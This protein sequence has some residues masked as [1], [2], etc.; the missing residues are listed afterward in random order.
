[1]HRLNL[2]IIKLVDLNTWIGEVYLNRNY[3]ATII[4]LDSPTVSPRGFLHRYYSSDGGNF[5]NFNNADYDRVYDAVLTEADTARRVGL[6]REAQ[7]IITED[8][9]SV[10]IQ[11][12]FY[13]IVLRSG[14]F[15]GALDY[16]LYVIDFSSLYKVSKH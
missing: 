15:S 16:P 11:D 13:F 9:A 3:Q 5:I 10:F 8:A 2:S 7:R 6:Y 12:I 1:M 4:S 14:V